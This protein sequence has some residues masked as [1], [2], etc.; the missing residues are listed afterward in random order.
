MNSAWKLLGN[1]SDHN[2]AKLGDDYLSA[3]VM[4]HKGNAPQ[5]PTYGNA[6]QALELYL[7][8][9]LL[10]RGKTL[11]YIENAIGHRLQVA[12]QE[13]KKLGL[14]LSG[15]DPKFI[16]KMMEFSRVYTRKDFQYRG[17]GE[18]EVFAPKDVIF[19]VRKV[20]DAVCGGK[21]I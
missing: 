17:S 4:L 11:H 19:F 15:G 21:Q 10:K 18:W 3:A 16:K 8:C 2:F 9:Y 5:W 13:C 12:L 1:D 20:R 6:F 7:K 14:D